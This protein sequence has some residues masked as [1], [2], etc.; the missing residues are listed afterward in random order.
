MI[1]NS[2]KNFFNTFIIIEGRLT[3]KVLKNSVANISFCGLVP[4]KSYNGPLLN[5]TDADKAK[6]AALQ[7][8]INQM[9]L[10]LYDLNRIYGSK[11]LT[12]EK[13][14]YVYSREEKLSLRIEELQE[15]IKTIK[16]NRIKKQV[17]E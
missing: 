4:K 13:L 1:Q 8:N 11:R 6:I 5:L 17:K 15:I 9:E 7:A 10:E 14:N 2:K 3:M 12:T 16:M